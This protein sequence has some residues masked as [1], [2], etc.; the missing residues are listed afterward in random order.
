V[1]V[2]DYTSSRNTSG[3]LA[4]QIHSGKIQFRNLQAKIL[5]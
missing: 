1:P 3:F 4:L 2:N 5:P